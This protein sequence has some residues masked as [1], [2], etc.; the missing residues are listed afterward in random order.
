MAETTQSD[1]PWTRRIELFE[2]MHDLLD[3]DMVA[4]GLIKPHPKFKKSSTQGYR[5]LESAYA[6]LCRQLPQ[7]L[8]QHI[9]QWDQI[10]LEKFHS[11]FVSGLDKEEWHHALNLKSNIG[12]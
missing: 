10:Y 3:A 5:L 1:T 11:G 8:L 9:P 7:E 12:S 2:D 4:Q 6:D